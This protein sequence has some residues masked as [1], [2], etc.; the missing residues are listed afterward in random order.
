MIS[1]WN[2]APYGGHPMDNTF[3][4]GSTPAAKSFVNPTFAAS[5]VNNPHRPRTH[6]RS[7]EPFSDLHFAHFTGR[8]RIQNITVFQDHLKQYAA[9]VGIRLPSSEDL[10][11]VL[12]PGF[13]LE[14]S[15]ITESYGTRKFQHA[16][17]ASTPTTTNISSI[18]TD[19]ESPCTTVDG[20][21]WIGT[22]THHVRRNHCAS[23]PSAL[24]GSHGQTGELRTADLQESDDATALIS[25]NRDVRSP[26]LQLELVL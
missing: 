21:N 15:S 16:H 22:G 8:P 1:H 13:Y 2:F 10:E 23:N 6:G 4:R 14:R 25:E 20:S 7:I 9:S 24:A 26:I 12:P 18:P 11:R 17:D 3:Y 5:T 19:T